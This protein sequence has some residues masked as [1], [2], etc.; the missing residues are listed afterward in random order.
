MRWDRSG[1]PAGSRRARQR[2]GL[3]SLVDV[4]FLLLVFFLLAGTLRA[5]SPLD[6]SPPES[7]AGSPLAESD[8][9]IWL[10]ADGRIAVGDE[11]LPLPIAVEVLGRPTGPVR[12]HADASARARDLLPLLEALRAAGVEDIELVVRERS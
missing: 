5:S 6:V 9:A 12:L 8:H 1:D 3:T 4:V 2:P 7:G 11:V 10:G